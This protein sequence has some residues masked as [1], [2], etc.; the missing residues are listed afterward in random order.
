[1]PRIIAV[2]YDDTLLRTR[3]VLLEQAGHTVRS[4]V[5]FQAALEECQAAAEVVVIG[6]S[7]PARD[8][9]EIINCFR[10]ANPKGIVVALTRAGE[11]R[12]KEVDA[13]ISPGDPADLL[14]AINFLL[15]GGKKRAGWN[16]RPIR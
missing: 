12:L 5:G 1:M 3:R 14:G 7:I 10:L 8:K 15:G 2:S 6:H 4:A 13:Y 11:D 9:I 16:V